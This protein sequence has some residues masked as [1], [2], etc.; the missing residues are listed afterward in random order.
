MQKVGEALRRADVRAIYLLHGTFVGA[1]AFGLLRQVSRLSETTGQRLKRLQKQVLD[2][3]AGEAANFT[4][5]Y[6]QSFEDAINTEATARIAIRRF[7]W[8]SENHH[9]GRCDAVVRLVDELASHEELRGGRVLLWGHSHGGN[10]L[11]LL[12]NLLAADP[13]TRREFF[14]AA[15]SYYRWPVLGKVDMP[16][17]PRVEE[18]L[19]HDDHPLREIELDYVTLGTPV[20]YG[21]EVTNTTKL[22]HFIHHRPVDGLP[23]DR[24]AF[25]PD[26]ED[27]LHARHGDYLQQFA[28]AG[29][30]FT[31][32]AWA[33]R[34]WMA[35]VRL[36]RLLQSDIRRRDLL[37]R[38]R[39]GIRAHD[40][41][42]SL[43]VD[44][45]P[46]EGH[47]GQHLAGHAVYTR[48]EWLLFHAE[49][50]AARFYNVS[51][52]ETTANGDSHQ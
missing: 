49:E 41:G 34:S 24:A 12:G 16:A 42:T 17:W 37:E 9:I 23:A 31:P 5:G 47:I 35:D 40:E 22:L 36:G 6:A 4:A 11:A 26:W 10:V 20:R 2:K 45:G 48:T 25:P 28:V 50:V 18:M 27:L 32:V 52:V 1:D 19:G 30:N 14:R 51:S 13:S 7:H 21:W 8:S 3:I 38:L 39:S 46:A 43:L 29:T 33:W 15:R 44:Y